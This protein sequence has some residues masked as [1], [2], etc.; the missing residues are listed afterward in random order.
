MMLHITQAS[1][2]GSDRTVVPV[3]I[4]RRCFWTGASEMYI[5]TFGI[6]QM[7]NYI[8]GSGAQNFP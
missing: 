6:N 8:N 5:M 1:D 2:E 3:H 4:R 7:K